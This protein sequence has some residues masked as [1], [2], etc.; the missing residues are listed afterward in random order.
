MLSPFQVLE[1]SCFYNSKSSVGG[2]FLLWNV[3][4]CLFCTK[5]PFEQSQFQR[6][7]VALTKSYLFELSLL[8]VS[9]EVFLKLKKFHWINI[10][11]TEMVKFVQ[12]VDFQQS[13]FQRVGAALVKVFL[14]ELILLRVSKFFKASRV[15]LDEYFYH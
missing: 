4:F 3:H 6:V 15:P 12:K 13:Q 11:N 2:I 5:I 8:R 9:G 10:F 1:R 14:F 7:D